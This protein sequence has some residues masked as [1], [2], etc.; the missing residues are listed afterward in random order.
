MPTWDEILEQVRDHPALNLLDR[1]LAELSKHVEATVI[2]YMSAF[3][4]KPI[5][6]EFR[7]LLSIIDQDMQ[8]FMTC[9]K[10]VSKHKLYLILHTPGGD[11]EATK[12][13]IHYLQNTY[14]KLV[15]AIPHLAM[16]GGT[17]IACAADEIH[18]GPYSSLGPTDPQ[19]QIGDTFIPAGAIVEEFSRA[20]EEVSK[21]PKRA[22]LWRE[23]L[24]GIPLGL[25]PALEVMQK[26]SDE[27]LSSLLKNRQLRN[28][29]DQ[30]IKAV[31]KLLNHYHEHTSHG[32][33]FTFEQVKSQLHLNVKNLHDDRDL[34][35]KVLSVYHIVTILFQQTPVCKIIANHQG[36]RFIMQLQT[37]HDLI[38]IAPLRQKCEFIKPEQK[39]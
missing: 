23:R 26:N 38:P 6:R 19:V 9:S 21:D 14:K 11:Y 34:E 30:E 33:A 12:R 5:P 31:V 4:V 39:K 15:V 24:K 32:L 36:K 13:I 10:G 27:Y 16:S 3:S 2:C 22:I 20:F 1:T 29:S 28:K 17:L 37:T 18:M 35:D 7:L 25:I 8:G